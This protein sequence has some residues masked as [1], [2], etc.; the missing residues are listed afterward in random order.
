MPSY[1]VAKSGAKAAAKRHQH[2]ALVVRAKNDPTYYASKKT[3]G[4]LE[5]WNEAESL[6]WEV[7]EIVEV[8]TT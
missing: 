1:A 8:P 5:A 4:T 7:V 3:D 6:G 2:P